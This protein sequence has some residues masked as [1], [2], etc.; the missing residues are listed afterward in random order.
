MLTIGMP[1]SLMYDPSCFKYIEPMHITSTVSGSRLWG[2]GDTGNLVTTSLVMLK[3]DRDI[4]TGTGSVVE[5][6][7]VILLIAM[8]NYIFSI[9]Y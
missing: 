1:S 3:E 6:S 4:D 2:Y 9:Q 5:K 7:I 8:R